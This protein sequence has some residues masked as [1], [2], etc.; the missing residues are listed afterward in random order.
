VVAAL[1]AFCGRHADQGEQ[2]KARQRRNGLGP[3]HEAGKSEP[4]LQQLLI[5][6]ADPAHGDECNAC[7]IGDHVPSTAETRSDV[8]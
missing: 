5:A 1:E 4:D 3:L 6:G 2:A 8:H 7:F